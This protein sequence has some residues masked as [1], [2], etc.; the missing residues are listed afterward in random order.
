M[1]WKTSEMD[2]DRGADSGAK[3]IAGSMG[4]S[5]WG[6]IDRSRAPVAQAGTN[7]PPRLS[8]APNLA[9]VM[10]RAQLFR[11]L[12]DDRAC[13]VFNRKPLDGNPRR[14]IKGST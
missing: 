1:P 4:L 5:D 9:E 10:A 8:E 14:F 2:W 6:G 13:A 3:S 7:P 12:P 11:A